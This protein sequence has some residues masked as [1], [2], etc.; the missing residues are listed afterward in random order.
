MPEPALLAIEN[1]HVSAAGRPVIEGV[2]LVIAPG[3]MLGLV[4]ESGCGKSVTA[5][6]VMRLLAEPPMRLSQGRILLDGPRPGALVET[7]TCN[8]CAA[9]TWR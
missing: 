3:E 4:G 1:L 9:T 8:R 6:A 7:A 2:D 5:L